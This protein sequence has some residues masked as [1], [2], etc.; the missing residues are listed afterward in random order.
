MISLIGQSDY[1]YNRREYL[2]KRIITRCNPYSYHGIS[3][4][5]FQGWTFVVIYSIFVAIIVI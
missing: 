4:L 2:I 5:L 3:E 1:Q